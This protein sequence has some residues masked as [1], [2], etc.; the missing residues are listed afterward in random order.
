MH[1]HKP[2]NVLVACERSLRELY[3]SYLDL[4]LV[5]WP[6]NDIPLADTLRG[7]AHLLDTGQVKNVGVS[8]FTS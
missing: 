5:H 6:N 2:T 3:L 8:N 7:L 4:F 1:G